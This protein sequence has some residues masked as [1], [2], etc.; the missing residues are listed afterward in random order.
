LAPGP[1]TLTEKSVGA[2]GP[3]LGSTEAEWL[4]RSEFVELAGQVVDLMCLL[5]RGIEFAP[6]CSIGR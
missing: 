4:S 2:D 6:Y 1:S 5:P 3:D